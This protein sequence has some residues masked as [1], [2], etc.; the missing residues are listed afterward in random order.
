VKSKDIHAMKIITPEED[1]S[2]AEFILEITI[3]KKCKH[4]NVTAHH[5]SWYKGDELFVSDNL[6]RSC[7]AIGTMD[8]QSL[9]DRR[10]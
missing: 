7:A 8:T 5:G 6:E 9:A 2:V 10:S 3:L 1:E 4:I